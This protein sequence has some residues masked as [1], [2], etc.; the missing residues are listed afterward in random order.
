MRI[1]ITGI[2]GFIGGHLQAFAEK[3]GHEVVGYSRGGGGGG[4]R[5]FGEGMDVGGIDA[6]V[7]LAGEPV[8]GVW[9]AR[10]RRQIMNSRVDGTRWVVEAMEKAGKDGPRVLVSG[11]ASGFY[12]DRGDERLEEGA[13]PGGGFL[14]EVTQNW[15][16]EAKVASGLARVVCLRTG[17]VLGRGGGAGKI[18]R[19]VF[20]LGLG[21]R[22]G[23][24]KQWVP[25]IHLEDEV[26]AIMKAV[27][28]DDLSGAVNLA[29]PG[30]ARNLDLTK[31]LSKTMGRPALFRVPSFV[32]GMSD[33]SREMFLFSQRVVP[34]KLEAAGFEF[35]HRDLDGALEEVF[36]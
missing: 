36:G 7:H 20:G 17:V 26:R 13:E 11:S 2:R 34:A 10:K 35:R 18:L 30:A 21:G 1:G 23:T 33:A 5:R 31:G 12:G 6:M 24:G 27:E 3:Q 4:L 29:A 25:W 32:L 28:C 16:A 15:E 19:R 14:A 9:T 8:L 22:L